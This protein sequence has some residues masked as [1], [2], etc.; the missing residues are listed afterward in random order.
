MQ[1]RFVDTILLGASAFC[2]GYA[3]AHADSLILEPGETLL[4]ELTATLRPARFENAQSAVTRDFAARLREADCLTESGVVDTPSL[5]PAV[6]AYAR[7]HAMRILFR[8]HFVEKTPENGGFTVTYVSV[9][10]LHRIGC[11][12]VL[13]APQ[14][15]DEEKKSVLRALVSD[16][17]EEQKTKIRAAGCTVVP[18]FTADEWVVSLPVPDADYAAACG[19][20]EDFWKERFALWNVQIDVMAQATDDLIDA[21]LGALFEAGVTA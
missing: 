18:G 3:A 11:R 14:V 8:S 17:T 20:F 6:A 13:S 21:D 16:V 4:P 5:A 10:G 2:L 9:D 1:S 19:Y 7:A 15:F 12:R